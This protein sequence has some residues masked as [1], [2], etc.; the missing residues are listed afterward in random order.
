MTD[1]DK[2]ELSETIRVYKEQQKRQKTEQ[3]K[4]QEMMSKFRNRMNLI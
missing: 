4:Y 2:K 3:E 1:L